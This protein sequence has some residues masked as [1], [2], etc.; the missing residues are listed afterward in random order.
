MIYASTVMPYRL[1]FLDFTP[2]DAWYVLD[3]LADVCFFFD[4][5]VNSF[6]AY[7]DEDGTLITKNRAIFINY[8]RSWFIFDIIACFP[9]TLLE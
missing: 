5:F 3:I 4:V 9:T 2:W 8:L 6:A 1:A 7:Y